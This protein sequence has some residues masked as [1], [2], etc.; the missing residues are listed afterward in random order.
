MQ[1]AFLQQFY[2]VGDVQTAQILYRARDTSEALSQTDSASASVQ[3]RL[4]E[5]HTRLGVKSKLEPV[6]CEQ[7]KK[8]NMSIPFST[9]SHLESEAP[10]P[11]ENVLCFKSEH[12]VAAG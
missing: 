4:P 2:L 12:E 10:C 3:G 8:R 7:S 6:S 1:K 11:R 9:H 5:H